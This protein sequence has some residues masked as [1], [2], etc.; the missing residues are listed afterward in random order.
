MHKIAHIFGISTDFL[1]FPKLE[2]KILAELDEWQWHFG[3]ESTSQWKVHGIAHIFGIST[4]FLIFS[5]LEPENPNILGSTARNQVFH[6][7]LQEM[8]LIGLY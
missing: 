2:L 3:N 8:G 7:M 6:I 4:D 1:I 5:K